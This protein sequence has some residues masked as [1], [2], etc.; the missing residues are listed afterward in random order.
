MQQMPD[1]TPN[2]PDAPAGA[3]PGSVAFWATPQCGLYLNEAIVRSGISPVA[4]GSAEEACRRELSAGR[5]AMV[6]DDP[7]LGPQEAAATALLSADPGLDPIPHLRAGRCIGTTEP[8]SPI[9]QGESRPVLLGEFIRTPGFRAAEQILESFGPIASIHVDCHCAPGQGSLSAR[10]HD[11]MRVLERLCGDMEMVDAMLIGA[12]AAQSIEPVLS[13]VSA[14]PDDLADLSGHIGVLVRHNPRSSSTVSA[15]DRSGWRRSVRILGAGGT[16]EFGEVGVN[17][18]DPVGRVIE[19]HSPADD[20]FAEACIHLGEEIRTL[21]Q[22]PAR[23]RFDD[24]SSIAHAAC[25]AVRLSCRTRA[26]E[27]LEKIRDL[28]ERT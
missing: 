19:H 25:E 26:P 7:R 23:A 4:V 18:T 2:D 27:S 15:T 17:W 20:L 24:S 8:L 21:V 1:G 9:M 12:N 5:E 22:T 14:T 3:E 28:L 6:Y 13:H 10:L 11:A 16:L